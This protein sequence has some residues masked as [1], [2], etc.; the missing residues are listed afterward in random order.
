[1]NSRT[2]FVIVI[3][4]AAGVFAPRIA[5]AQLCLQLN[6]G[7]QAVDFNSLATTGTNNTSLPI[8]FAFNESGASGNLT[9]AAG[10]GSSSTANTYSFG[11]GTDTDRALGE[12]TA[13]GVVST[14]GACFVNNT[15]APLNSFTI[16][17]TGELWRLGAADITP[18]RLDFQYSLNATSVST[19]TWTDV[20]ALD[21]VTPNNAGPN[22]AKDG[23]AALN[24]TVFAPTTIYICDTPVPQGGVIFIRWLPTNIAGANDGLAIDDFSITVDS[25]CTGDA[26]NDSTVNVTDLL[27]VIANWG[28]CK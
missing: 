14:I 20:N 2:R 4:I 6:G 19:G 12:L 5:F 3:T 21:F 13:S 24:R 27:A 26:N 1:M 18:D 25:N 10:D 9:Y 22:G 15:G 16:A 11:T 28:A 23:N 7:S 17:Y 8:G